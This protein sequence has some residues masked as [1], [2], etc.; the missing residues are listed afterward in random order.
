MQCYIA[1]DQT[2]H[3]FSNT[4]TFR[5]LLATAGI[6]FILLGVSVVHPYFNSMQNSPQAVLQTTDNSACI[7]SP[8]DGEWSKINFWDEEIMRAVEKVRAE[9]GVTVPPNRIKAHMWI[10]SGGDPNAVQENYVTGFAYG[11]MQITRNAYTAD[12]L[13]FGRI[14]EPSYNIYAGTLEL[15]VRYKNASCDKGWDGASYGYFGGDPCGAGLSDPYTNYSPASYHA[16]LNELIDELEAAGCREVSPDTEEDGGTTSGR[17]TDE[18]PTKIVLPPGAGFHCLGTTCTSSRSASLPRCKDTNE[19]LATGR[20]TL[21]PT[22]S[23]PPS[24]NGLTEQLQAYFDDLRG[25]LDRF[26]TDFRSEMDR[27]SESMRQNPASP[28]MPTI[29]PVPKVTPFSLRDSQPVQQPRQVLPPQPIDA[30]DIPCI[31]ETI[32]DQPEKEGTGEQRDSSDNRTQ[33][34]EPTDR[35]IPEERPEPADDSSGP[36]DTADD[37]ESGIT[38]RIGRP[39]EDL[40][41]ENVDDI[42]E[43]LCEEYSVCP[44]L[45]EESPPAGDWSLDSLKA[46]WNIVQRMYQS[47]TFVEYA[48]GDYTLELTRL[49]THPSYQGWEYGTYMG[50]ASPSYSTIQ[51]SR[52]ITIFDSAFATNPSVGYWEWLLAHEIAHSA[53]RG[54]EDG[55]VGAPGGPVYDKIITFPAVSG[56]GASSPDENQ[57]DA[58]SFYLT[59]G[60]EVVAYFGSSLKPNLKADFPDLYRVLRDGYF[61]GQEF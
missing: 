50:H 56:Y 54:R 32:V 8:R 52:L 47:P 23:A 34:N 2:R 42:K 6:V 40:P 21:P 4:K 19:S 25:Q 30:P 17:E 3:S 51:N 24:G 36:R 1:M 39:V 26:F 46:L 49:S 29:P 9:E 48:I 20:P 38:P 59:R 53:G 11:L 57:A 35:G 14:M 10:E 45:S 18:S 22:S 43:V 55:S 13:D 15:A 60:E 58:V 37:T 33:G 61:D 7:G 5:S 28:R 16:K 27:F 31:E 44:T 41:S 12:R